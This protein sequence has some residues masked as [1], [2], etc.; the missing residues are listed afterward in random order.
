MPTGHDQA[1]GQMIMLRVQLRL[2]HTTEQVLLNRQANSNHPPSLWSG[3]RK[4]DQGT[5]RH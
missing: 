3:V 4:F 1:G 5:R 2:E